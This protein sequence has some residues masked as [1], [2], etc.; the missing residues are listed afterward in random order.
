M[1]AGPIQFCCPTCTEVLS[2]AGDVL[3]CRRCKLAYPQLGTVRCCYPNPA[4]DLAAWRASA[5]LE[6]QNLIEDQRETHAASLISSSTRTRARLEHLASAYS[7]QIGHLTQLLA[8]IIDGTPTSDKTTYEALNT[9]AL[10]QPTTLFG[11][12][13]NVF[14]DWAWGE[15]E[16]AQAI[17]LI[18]SASCALHRS[19]HTFSHSLGNVLVLGAGAGR[20]A[21]D[22]STLTEGAVVAVDLNP[23]TSLLAA[24]LNAGSR[25]E[26]WEFPL[27]PKQIKDVAVKHSLAAPARRDNLHWLLADARRPPFGPRSFDTVVTPWY[28]DVVQNPPA[29]TAR[30]VNEL[31]VDGGQWL[32]F[33][34]AT[35]AT[36]DIKNRL[37]LEELLELVTHSGFDEPNC[38]EATGP[39]LRSPHSRFSRVEALHAF[40]AR[41]ASHCDRPAP[42]A[43]PSWLQDCSQSVPALESFQ[44]QAM[45]TQVHAFLMALI[46]DR[47][48]IND[49]AQ[50]LQERQLMD[51]AEAVP[52]V[53]SFL[54][55]LYAAD[56]D[57]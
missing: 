34:S 32:N 41:K 31:L 1:H 54:L 13:A 5:H 56:H 20:L 6:L 50:V 14:R 21:W 46:D 39:Y 52:V 12:A 35:F 7:S 55:K 10:S 44:H 28:T 49:I 19:S 27:A 45:S 29:D 4:T 24:E 33:G 57:T 51:A 9:Q 22:L 8:P 2:G 17:E 53:Q 26:L 3:L 16:N 48:S 47:R 36:S 38:V 23:F 40:A 25:V 18:R 15:Q 30:R 42:P 43:V 11:Y 37:T